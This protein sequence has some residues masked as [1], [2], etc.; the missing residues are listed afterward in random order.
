M[1]HLRD[2]PLGIGQLHRADLL[3]KPAVRLGAL[4]P[5][6]TLGRIRILHLARQSV[7]GRTLLRARA[8]VQIVVRIPQSFRNQGVHHGLVAQSVSI[9]RLRQQVGCLAHALRA[10]GDA[11]P[12]L[13]GRD[14]EGRMKDG[15]QPGAADVIDGN[16]ARR[17]KEARLECRLPDRSLTL[18]GRQDLTKDQVGHRIDP[19]PGPGQ[20]PRHGHGTQ[21]RSGLGG[22][23]TLKCAERGAGG[24]QNDGWGLHGRF[25]GHGSAQ[26]RGAQTTLRQNRWARFR[27]WQSGPKRQTLPPLPPVSR[28]HPGRCLSPIGRIARRQRRRT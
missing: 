28:L 14:Q 17:R 18:P 1:L 11:D 13:V 25:L 23:R 9:P 15:M 2:L 4:R 3:R 19:H 12:G 24:G 16:G 7:A 27:R 21:L 8:H 10:A 5:A 6:K 22:Q 26:G 20:R